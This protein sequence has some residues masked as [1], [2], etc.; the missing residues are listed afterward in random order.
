MTGTFNSTV[1]AQISGVASAAAA[2]TP[3]AA[4]GTTTTAAA[5]KTTAAGS[6]SAA[7]ASASASATAAANGAISATAPGVVSSTIGVGMVMSFASFFLGALAFGLRIGGVPL[8]M[9]KLKLS[10]LRC[11]G[12]PEVALELNST[13]ADSVPSLSSPSTASLTASTF[14]LRS[15]GF[16]RLSRQPSREVCR[17][18]QHQRSFSSP[19][20]P[21]Y[22]DNEDGSI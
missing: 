8:A 14:L 6:A 19:P 7:K 9:V 3:A 17:P 4:A 22:L 13:F 5:A 21:V 18:G 12:K 10:R 2:T 20:P 15:L 1:Q 11:R 16:T